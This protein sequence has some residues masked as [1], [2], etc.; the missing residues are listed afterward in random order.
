MRQLPRITSPKTVEQP[1]QESRT[2]EDAFSTNILINPQIDTEGVPFRSAIM[3]RP[4]D[5]DND[6]F[7]PA[8]EATQLEVEDLKKLAA[9]MAARGDSSLQDALGLVVQSLNNVANVSEVA[10]AMKQGRRVDISADPETGEIT[11]TGSGE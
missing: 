2:F 4:Y 1:A 6:V 10:E 8:N 3:M 9:V 5:Y 7:G 11:A